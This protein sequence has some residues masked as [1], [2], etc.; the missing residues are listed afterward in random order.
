VVFGV[1]L[2]TVGREGMAALNGNRTRSFGL[3]VVNSSTDFTTKN[4]TLFDE[5]GLFQKYK[6]Y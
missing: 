2:D 5:A 3:Y 1:D 6:K 4:N